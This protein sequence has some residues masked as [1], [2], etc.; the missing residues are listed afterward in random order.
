MSAFTS[1]GSAWLSSSDQIGQRWPVTVSSSTI[2]WS[3]PSDAPMSVIGAAPVLA[4][5][6]PGT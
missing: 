1:T 5:S 6:R 2:G 4:R 3:A